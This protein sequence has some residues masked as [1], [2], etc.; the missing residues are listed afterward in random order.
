MIYTTNWIERLNKEIRMTIKI[1]N[2]FHNVDSALNLI[3]F[4]LLNFE[5]LVYKYPVTAFY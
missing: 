5:Q 4:A 2:S 3:C 1:R